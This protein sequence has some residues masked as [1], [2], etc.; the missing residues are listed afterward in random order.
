VVL[1]TADTELG[2]IVVDGEG[3]VIYQF[4]SDEQ[5]AGAST[6]EGQCAA[7][8]PA[9]PGDEMRAPIRD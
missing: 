8:W 9:I 5:G 6:C 2:T 1:R 3:M 7:T 4:D